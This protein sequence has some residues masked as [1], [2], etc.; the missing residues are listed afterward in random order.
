MKNIKNHNGITLMALVITI[1]ILII[2]TSIRTYS[3]I[4]ILKSAQFT[5]F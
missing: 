4:Q 5:A 2:I 1:I 3:V